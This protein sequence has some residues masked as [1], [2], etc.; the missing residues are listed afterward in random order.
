M[1]FRGVRFCFSGKVSKIVF[2][3]IKLREGFI[4]GGVYR[5]GVRILEL[6]VFSRGRVGSL[7]RVGV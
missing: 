6:G 7:G 2:L 5:R 1:G 3:G 4:R